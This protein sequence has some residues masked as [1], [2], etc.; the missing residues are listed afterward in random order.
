MQDIQKKMFK[1]KKEEEKYKEN[2]NIQGLTENEE[3]NEKFSLHCDFK[4]ESS[5]KNLSNG[6]KQII[7]FMRVLIQN[8]EIIC[9]DEAT[10]NLDP[11]TGKLMLFS[12]NYN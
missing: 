3:V 7:N 5:G 6:E 9:M 4:I 2:V 12:Y 1:N 8:N 10:S 11:Y